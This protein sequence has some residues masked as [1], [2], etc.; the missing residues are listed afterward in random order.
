MQSRQGSH[1]DIAHYQGPNTPNFTSKGFDESSNAFKW[2]FKISSFI[3]ILVSNLSR[4]FNDLVHID[5]SCFYGQFS[6]L[7]VSNKYGTPDSR[8]VSMTGLSNRSERV[9]SVPWRRWSRVSALE[10]F[11]RS[12]HGLRFSFSIYSSTTK[13]GIG[14]YFKDDRNFWAFSDPLP[15]PYWDLSLTVLIDHTYGAFVD[16]YPLPTA[17]VLKVCPLNNLVRF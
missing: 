4:Y 9:Q 13:G 11:Y 1:L 6:W 3:M 8:E 2:R 5:T 10:G 14:G 16:P 12:G 17:F 15:P 7:M